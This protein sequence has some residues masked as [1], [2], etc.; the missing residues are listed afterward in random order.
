MSA[1]NSSCILCNWRAVFPRFTSFSNSNNPSILSLLF[2]TFTGLKRDV[3]TPKFNSSILD[4]IAGNAV[5]NS[6]TLFLI[7]LPITYI[8]CASSNACSAYLK[9]LL[10]FF[11]AYSMALPWGIIAKGI[12]RFL[13]TFCATTDMRTA[14]FA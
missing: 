4:S 11:T 12:L 7:S 3:L 6:F 1:F 8:R 10:S 2:F 13:A 9:N 5:N 14:W